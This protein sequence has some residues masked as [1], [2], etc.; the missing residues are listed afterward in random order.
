[1]LDNVL[2]PWEDMLVHRDTEK[3]LSF[4]PRS[5]FLNGFCFQGCTRYAVKLDFLAGAGG[6]G[7]ARDRRRRVPRQ[8]GDAR[9]DR[10]LARPVLVALRRDGVNPQPWVG[11]ALCPI[12]SRLAY[13]AF[14]RDA[15]PQIK[16]IIEKSSP[17][18]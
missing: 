7:A 14:A 9:R 4:H 13:R 15:Y 8:P 10:R 11:D 12:W 16:E 2:I 1:M 18:R 6:E 17:R 3:I 5:G